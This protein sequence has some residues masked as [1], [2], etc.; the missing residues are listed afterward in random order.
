MR[1]SGPIGL[2]FLCLAAAIA[3]FAQGTTSRVVGTVEDPTGAAIAGATVRL[4]NEG[5]SVVFTANTSVSGAYLF[6]AVQSGR[7]TV[8]VEA[9]G[10]RKFASTANQ[11]S[12]GQPTTVNVT[13]EVGQLTEHVTVAGTAEAVQTSTSGNY[14][15]LFE[16]DVI[17]DLPIVGTRGRNPLSL[18]LLQPGVVSGANTGGGVHVH[19]ARDRA[20]N[21]TLD[22]V[23]IN[24]TSGGGGNSAPLKTNPDSIAEFRVLTSNTTA[25]YGR[26][27]GGQVA[28][29]TRS[30]TNEFH[31]GLF[32]F[33]RTPRL[34]ANEWEY[35]IDNIGKR[36][37]VQHTYGGS[38]GGP[39]IRNRTFFF[40]NVQLLG[41]LQTGSVNRTVYTADA[42][43]GILRYVKGGR[44]RPAGVAGASVDAAGN[45]LPGV[46]IGTYN[47]A[48]SDPQRAGLDSR[49]SGLTG[50]SP[51]PNNFTGGDG[52][53]T[54]FYT[55]AADEHERQRD[56]TFKV[57]HILTQKN[58]VFGRVAWGRQDTEC[59]SANAGQRMFPGEQC[60]VNTERGPRNLAFNWRTNPTP[61]FT[62]ELV[63]GQNQFVYNFL[64]PGQTLENLWIQGPVSLPGVLD[65]GNMR[66]LKTLQFV[67]NAAWFRGSHSLKFG[68]NGRYQQ[69]ID[70]RG[71]V[72]GY[73]VMQSI[74]FSTSINTVDPATFGIPSD[75]NTTFDRPTF[76]SAINTLL[77]RVGNNTRAFVARGGKYV[78]DTY[79]FD[80]RYPEYDF[81]VQ[82]TWKLR[83][84]LTVD[85]G[86]R[87][88]AKL[89][90]RDAADA[91]LRPNQ[92][93]TTGAA[94]SNTLRWVKGNLYESNWGNVGPSL[95]FA[96]DPTGGGKTSVRANYRM[97][98]DRINTFVLSSSVFQN[99]PG[100]TLGVVNTEFGQKGGRLAA[101]PELTA[102]ATNP[103][104]FAQ[105]IPFSSGTITVVDPGLKTPTT[106]QWA[107]S[108][109]REVMRRTVVE[110]SY[111]GRRAYHLFGAYNANQVNIF[112]S[113]F[114][115][116]FRIV[117]AGGESDLINRL[118]AADS[119]KGA[120]ESGSAM[121]RRLYTS[122]LNL[123]S[124]GAVANSL[125][126]RLQGGRSVTDLS[127]AGPFPLISWPQ[128]GGSMR[129][130]DSNDFSTYHAL[131]AQIERRF[132]NGLSFQASYTWAKSL[133][134]RSFDPSQTVI[135]TANNQQASS[136]PFDIYNRRLNYARSDFD[137]AHALQTNW[138]FELPFGQGKRWAGSAGKALDA[139][140]G[141][142]EVAG[143]LRYWAG[144][145]FTVY[146]G[147]YNFSNVVQTP[148]N[149]S[150]CTSSSGGVYDET[151]GAG[152]GLV[153]FFNQ[154]EIAT[155]SN[156]APGQF[157]NTG[158]NFFTGPPS[159]N[160]DLALLKRIRF[161][162]RWKLQ[163]R[164]DATNLTNTPTFGFP[165]ATVTSSTFGR[166]RNTVIS[167]SRKI[168]LG[169]KLDF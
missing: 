142:W 29:I 162:E 118:T 23:D 121:V 71:S 111:I 94:P 99:L 37:F 62:N 92:P 140:I 26:N 122:D 53:N 3:A 78:S 18:V 86:L 114:L 68:F 145:P 96:W 133:D 16:G 41:A 7:Y 59:D 130:V 127:G 83:K 138:V 119:R 64:T 49:I 87:W 38:V 126:T 51:L 17:R 4:I 44:N 139:V 147:A 19:G 129:V 75:V 85:L 161:T 89:T 50:R 30:G 24:E 115:D 88:E 156:P 63:V 74:D 32:W 91:V 93:V 70:D 167:G 36:Q 124:V 151:T 90:P 14:G 34:N 154:S 55:F 9:A 112:S 66:T 152:A 2:F 103:A 117:K 104:E 72:A 79:Q 97:A 168:Q 123:N 77:G 128:F 166:I 148:A 22:G 107:F 110:V 159:F 43:K 100:I 52:L 80:A 113:G 106:H 120:G 25:E 13:L 134:T 20:W 45:V 109:Q 132:S 61:T 160:T 27:S 15:N 28:M 8:E 150:G 137:R 84:N 163:L 155:F 165:T 131:E 82:D 42:R 98:F 73:N 158:R 169:V 35:N 10:F 136:T 101:L 108:V 46:D 5:T 40:A 143:F 102:P 135:S 21:Y 39:I 149:C 65:Y 67:D 144:R 56:I 164:A 153:W 47:V 81:Y 116:A 105:P 95:G 125:A 31:G 33:Y 58:T 48:T 57:D 6:E 141:G 11:V 1:K 60:G 12:I 146:S 76:Q 54:A 69:H 157:G